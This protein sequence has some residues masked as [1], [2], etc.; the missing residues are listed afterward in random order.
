MHPSPPG[1][2]TV[3]RESHA[4]D[5]LQASGFPKS[6]SCAG[7]TQHGSWDHI[8]LTSYPRL[9][10]LRTLSYNARSSAVISRDGSSK[11]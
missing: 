11:N 9:S 5:T 10:S 8:I 3:G 4:L 7:C 1:P 2:P 6:A